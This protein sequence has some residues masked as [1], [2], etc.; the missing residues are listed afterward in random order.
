MI[1]EVSMDDSLLD[2]ILPVT[3]GDDAAELGQRLA[4][5]VP[6]IIEVGLCG[7]ERA[8]AGAT[9]ID[10]AVAAQKALHVLREQ[11]GIHANRAERKGPRIAAEAAAVLFR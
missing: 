11:K 6:K 4:A 9:A 8:L 10:N 1:A 3:K 2:P 5:L 7:F